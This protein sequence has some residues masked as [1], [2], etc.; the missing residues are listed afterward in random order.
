MKLFHVTNWRNVEPILSEGLR[1]DAMGWN[2][3]YVW[4][5]DDLA[6]AERMSVIGVWGAER[7]PH[8][9][10]EVDVTGLRIVPD[11]HA[12]WGDERDDHSF[13]VPHSIE[14]ERINLLTAVAA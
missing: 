13:A 10:L 5:F 9:I 11:P 1:V 7:G 12:G 4:G 8:A 2:T 3:G 6:V 14:P